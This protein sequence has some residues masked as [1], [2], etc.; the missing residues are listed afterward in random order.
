MKNFRFLLRCILLLAVVY[1]GNALTSYAQTQDTSLTCVFYNLEN[2]FHP[3]DAPSKGD[4]EFTPVGSR[5]WS[6]QR[7]HQK[8]TSVCKVLLSIDNWK[9][10]DIICMCEIENREVAEDLIKH[11]L[12][13][14]SNYDI[15]HRESPDHRDLDAMILYDPLRFKCIDTTWIPLVDQR[16]N[17]EK[18]REMVAAMFTSAK[19]TLLCIAAHWTSK[20]GGAYETE[21]KRM[22][23]AR[24]LATYIDSILDAHPG[25]HLIA[26]GDF[27]DNSTSK[28]IQI[29]TSHGGIREV[30]PENN[31]VT[32]KYQGKWERI[33]HV[34]IGQ[35]HMYRQC[36]CKVYSPGFLLEADEKYS[37]RKPYRTYS[38]YSYN[39]GI[40]DHLP[41]LL[42]LDLRELQDH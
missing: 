12:M 24:I 4:D 3:S 15:I 31:A 34:F 23:Q 26:G 14:H 32:Y 41:L 28:S 42:T 8:I 40:S 21:K 7:Y 19:D 39:G 29:L 17:V 35:N 9:L 5:R 13:M 33:D 16:G 38:G 10:P 18:T 2:L 37:G 22:D 20:Y 1:N 25:I 6:W 11:P 36:Y 30:L 27:N